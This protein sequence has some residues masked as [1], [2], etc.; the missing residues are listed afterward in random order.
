MADSI[1]QLGDII[2]EYS[3]KQRKYNDRLN[4][5]EMK[6]FGKAK[7]ERKKGKTNQNKENS[8]I[9]SSINKQI[10]KRKKSPNVSKQIKAKKE[11]SH[12]PPVKEKLSQSKNRNLS[13]D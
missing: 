7:E 12:S 2:K 13:K 6:L 10:T 5:C 4:E 9:N 1:E 11:Q 8:M 3:K